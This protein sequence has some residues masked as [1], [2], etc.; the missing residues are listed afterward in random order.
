MPTQCVHPRAET[1]LRSWRELGRWGGGGGGL[2]VRGIVSTAITRAGGGARWPPP[3]FD[4]EGRACDPQAPHPL[5]Q[6]GPTLPGCVGAL[7]CP[8]AAG[9]GW[10]RPAASGT[11]TSHGGFQGMG[12]GRSGPPRRHVYVFRASGRVA[13]DRAAWAYFVGGYRHRSQPTF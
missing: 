2:G 4:G 11:V 12:V 7:E 3:L 9:G 13:R 6:K 8:P 10:R 1:P 5:A